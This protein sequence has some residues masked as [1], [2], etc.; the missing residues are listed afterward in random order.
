MGELVL[1][2]TKP[3]Y[4]KIEVKKWIEPNLNRFCLNYESDISHCLIM[5][6]YCY[7]KCQLERFYQMRKF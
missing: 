4:I 1:S 5:V 2:Q 7:G 6:K 3:F